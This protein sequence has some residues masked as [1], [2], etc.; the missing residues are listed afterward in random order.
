MEDDIKTVLDPW[1]GGLLSYPVTYT[2]FRVK[3]RI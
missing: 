1:L 2:S 3:E